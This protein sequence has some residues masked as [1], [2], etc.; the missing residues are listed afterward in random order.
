MYGQ[1]DTGPMH[2]IYIKE[3][4][5]APYYVQ[6]ITTT[7]EELLKGEELVG[8]M[9]LEKDSRSCEEGKAP[10]EKKPLVL[11]KKVLKQEE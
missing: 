7:F 4:E 9:P 10:I 1:Q 8:V 2:L 5:L 11:E 6:K 3:V